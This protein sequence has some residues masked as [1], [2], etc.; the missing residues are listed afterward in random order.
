MRDYRGWHR[1]SLAEHPRPDHDRNCQSTWL[2]AANVDPFHCQIPRNGRA[3][4]FGRRRCSIPSAQRRIIG[5]R[6]AAGDSSVGRDC[7]NRS[8]SFINCPVLNI[9]TAQ[10][11]KV[12]AE[13]KNRIVR[14]ATLLATQDFHPIRFT[15]QLAAGDS[16]HRLFAD[17]LGPFLIFLYL[18][19]FVFLCPS[20][21]IIVGRRMHNFFFVNRSKVKGLRLLIAFKVVFTKRI[22]KDN[23]QPL[24]RVGLDFRNL[25][26][27]RRS[28]QNQPVGV[29]IKPAAF[30][31][32][33]WTSTLN[34]GY[35]STSLIGQHHEHAARHHKEAAKHYASGSNECVCMA[36]QRHKPL[37]LASGVR[38]AEGR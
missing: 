1:A 19:G 23:S 25:Q 3:R 12:N 36:A 11:K 32:L 35:S 20:F 21:F 7:K 29:E 5:W 34:K 37:R 22:H 14:Q 10:L 33:K 4:G 15:L 28:I 18:S 16:Q 38:A 13:R 6:Q 9:P 24:G 8:S 26:K 27:Y 2:H 30:F 17:H 31:P